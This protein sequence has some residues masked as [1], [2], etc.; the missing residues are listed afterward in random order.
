MKK[1]SIFMLVV[2]SFNLWL[3]SAVYAANFADPF[4]LPE[5]TGDWRTDYVAVAE[6]QLGYT[7]A[8]DE[9]SYFGAWGD[10]PYQAWCS[11]F[12]SW[13][14]E[15][16]DIPESIIPRAWWCGDWYEFFTYPKNVQDRYFYLKEGIDPDESNFIENYYSEYYD[17]QYQ[18][19]VNSISI[20]E[21]EPGDLILTESDGDITNGPD[22]TAIF[23]SYEDGVVNCISGNSNDSVRYGTFSLDEIHILCKPDFEN[24]DE[25]F[26]ED[27]DID[28]EESTTAADITTETTTVRSTSGGGGGGGSSSVSA[29]TTTTTTEATTETTTDVIETTTEATTA[30]VISNDVKV[31]IGSNTVV[32]G[33]NSYT[34]DA[35]SYIQA[36]SNSTLVPLRFVAIAILG[37]DI[38]NADNSSIIGWNAATKTASITAN[39][40]VI[41]FTA[42]SNI[43]NI[44]GNSVSMDNGV[45][46]E[47]TDGRMYIPF[48][49][50]GNALGVDVDWDSDTKTAIY[51]TM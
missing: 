48:R 50:L 42:N 26:E 38:E 19:D 9:S 44:N 47:I 49:A 25:Y 39:G 15:Q 17:I 32:V 51:K 10:D 23:L 43:M 33:D 4:P 12:A 29:T 6:S 46:A 21:A 18:K 34:M 5:L 45:I 1:L 31:S 11:E 37:D 41:Q 14:G 20:N 24:E 35:A 36:S 8:D 2:M 40:N 3:S 22:H 16:A 7:E 13:C 30:S 28:D 27:E